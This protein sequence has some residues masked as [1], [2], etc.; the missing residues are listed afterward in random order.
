MKHVLII[1]SGIA[2]LATAVRLAH[3]GYRV[4]VYERNEKAGGKLGELKRNGFRFDTGPSLFTMPHYVEELFVLCGKNP[5]DYFRY[6]K[7]KESCRY[8]WDDGKRIIADADPNEFAKACEESFAVSSEKIMHYF[9][10]S[11]KAFS[12]TR[13]VF[14][15]QSLHQL[16]NYWS[17]DV[18]KGLFQI[19]QLHIFKSMHQVNRK[20]LQEPHLVQLFDRF[21]TYNGSDPYRAPGILTMIPHLEH[22][23]GTFFPANGM[24]AIPDALFRLAQEM[25]VRFYFSS[26]VERIITQNKKAIGVELKGGETIK[27]DVVVSNMDVVPTYRR[28][29]RNQKAPERILRQERSSSALIFY[30]GM[31]KEFPVLGLHNIFFSDDYKNEFEVL[32]SGKS[33]SDDPTVYLHI[34]SKYCKSDAPEGKENW[35][36]LV[37]VP[38]NTGQDWQALIPKIRANVIRK[39]SRVL[40]EEIASQIESEDTLDPLA[41]EER[42]S[43]H[44][45]SLYGAASNSR[46]AAFLRHPNFS[47]KIS[48]LYF[49][50]GSVHPGGGIP[51]CLLSGKITAAIIQQKSG[52]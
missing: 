18:L 2:S 35:F 32:F 3:A 15:E 27:A 17:A 51:L 41:I 26:S 52:T 33:V 36:V 31:K 21:A 8:F 29:L 44:Q 9:A 14:L 25:G 45:G 34:S 11:A 4:D 6:E 19:G 37:N 1:G 50:G 47:P 43:S 23:I 10:S 49:C 48:D 39:L 40:G 28:L 12:I 13:K 7:V 22:N 20:L 38:G 5:A 46:F 30:W 16:R 24:I 42:S